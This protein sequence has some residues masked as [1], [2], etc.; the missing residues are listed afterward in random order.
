MA[1]IK[2]KECGEEISS[3]AKKCP[4]CGKDQRNFFLRHKI[5]TFILGVIA[6]C[7]I[8]ISMTGGNDNT[9]TSGA[10]IKDSYNV[11]EIYEDSNIKLTF[12][13]FDED[14][15]KYSEYAEI[16]NDCKILKAEFELE[17]IGT[18]DKFADYSDFKCYADGYA[19]DDFYSVDD[20]GLEGPFNTTLS[21]GKKVRGNIYFQVPKNAEKVT[22]EYTTN[23][24][25][26]E[27]VVFN[28]K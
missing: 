14:F 18:S 12:I 25:V 16:K 19:C 24:F 9:T 7:I 20:A 22:I 4:K 6:L 26:D 21:A 1:M 28:I 5:L 8:I 10:P 2:C 27:K 23:M 13:S 17:N 11:S 3:S 15:K